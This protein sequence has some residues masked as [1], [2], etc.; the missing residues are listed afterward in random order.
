MLS[1]AANFTLRTAQVTRIMSDLNFGW[2]VTPCASQRYPDYRLLSGSGYRIINFV[3]VCNCRFSQIPV[4]NRFVPKTSRQLGGGGQ[5]GA[6]GLY[7]HVDFNVFPKIC[8]TSKRNTR[9]QK[10]TRQSR[11]TRFGLAWL[12]L[13]W[14]GL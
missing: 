14:S 12:G 7:V 8:Q 9:P 11:T 5:N 2:G 6:L 3:K 10:K 4:P 13:A 1:A